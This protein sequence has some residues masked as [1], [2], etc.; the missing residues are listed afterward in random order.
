MKR[1][2]FGTGGQAVDPD[3]KELLV[4][5]QEQIAQLQ[6]R[7]RVLLANQLLLLRWGFA[8]GKA[9]HRH[10][11]LDKLRAAGLQLKAVAPDIE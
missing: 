7:Q 5:M 3:L 6:D 9:T 4:E 2:R 11:R 10:D 1:P 8:Q